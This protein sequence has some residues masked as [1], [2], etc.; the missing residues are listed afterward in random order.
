MF[1]LMLQL[2]ILCNEKQLDALFSFNIFRQ[3]TSTCFGHVYC[4]SSE[5]IHCIRTAI[6]MR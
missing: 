3:S 2:D 6:G 1:F 4:P 5:G